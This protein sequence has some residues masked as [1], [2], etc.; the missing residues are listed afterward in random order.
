MDIVRRKRE[1][2]VRLILLIIYVMLLNLFWWLVGIIFTDSFSHWLGSEVFKNIGN[3]LGALFTCTLYALIQIFVFPIEKKYRI[4]IVAW[5]FH[6]LFLWLTHNDLDGGEIMFLITAEIS[7]FNSLIG[8]IIF[9]C[10]FNSMIA[11]KDLFFELN[12]FYLFP[13]YL[14]FVGYSYRFLYRCFVLKKVDS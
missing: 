2:L 1:K 13:L 14:L 7:Q 10:N 5:V 8:S 9:D 12:D 6:T 3:F 4:I 11:Y